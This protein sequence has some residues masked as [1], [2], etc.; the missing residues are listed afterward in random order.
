MSAILLHNV[1]RPSLYNSPTLL[2]SVLLPHT[3]SILPF[4]LTIPQF[5]LELPHCSHSEVELS[6][7]SSATASEAV[8]E[9]LARLNL[10]E[11][12]SQQGI[13]CALMDT[14]SKTRGT[15]I[16][17]EFLYSYNKQCVVSLNTSCMNSIF[18][19]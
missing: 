11:P 7:S 1:L 17:V 3:L 4:F 13:Q 6:L 18:F 2:F 10:A 15:Y 19:H 14:T 12:Y 8:R 5:F 16:H 9:V